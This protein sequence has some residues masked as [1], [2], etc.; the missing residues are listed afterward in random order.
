M[1]DFKFSSTVKT[2]ISC[3]AISSVNDFEAGPVRVLAK[4][5]YQ[6]FKLAYSVKEVASKFYFL[7]FWQQIGDRR[8][9]I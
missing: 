5:C 7:E 6:F 2:L 1:S 9:G 8:D 3:C 4:I